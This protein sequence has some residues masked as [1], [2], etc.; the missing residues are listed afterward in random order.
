MKKKLEGGKRET[1]G[2]LF[3][4]SRGMKEENFKVGGEQSK[5][6]LKKKNATWARMFLLSAFTPLELVSDP[7]NIAIRQRRSRPYR[8]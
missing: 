7:S 1:N 8:K 6:K 4:L 2:S 3:F 5:R